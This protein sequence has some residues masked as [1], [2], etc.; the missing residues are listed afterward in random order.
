MRF[1]GLLLVVSACDDHLFVSHGNSGTDT[2]ENAT[3]WCAVQ[4]IIN[5]NCLT[6]QAAT[7]NPI[8]GLDLETDP[9]AALVNV[10]SLYD[11]SMRV[12]PNDPDGSL[13]VRKLEGDA[14]GI[15][16]PTGALPDDRIQ[17]VRDWIADGAS[18]VCE[19]PTTGGT[20]PN[21]YHPEGWAEPDVHGM[22]TKFQTETD[23]RTCHGDDLQGGSVGIS[24]TSCHG[25]GW[26]TTC[27]FCHGDP[28]D[29]TGAPPQDIDD[30]TNMA[31]LSFPPHRLH[32]DSELHA[33]WDC[34]QCHTKPTSA[35]F[36][37]HLFV[38]DTPGQAE[39][40]FAA[41][42]SDLGTYDGNGSC[43]NLY[44]HGN[45]RGDNGSVDLTDNVT[46]ESCHT[47]G[48]LGGQ[49]DEHLDEGAQCADCHDTVNTQVDIVLPAQHVNGV[50]NLDLPPGITTVGQNCTGSCHLGDE[51]EDHEGYNWITGEDD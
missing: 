10:P 42:L 51:T 45:G 33:T 16:P 30:N 35:L 44:C 5:G 12:A 14:G 2:T 37:G 6:C 11:G 17:L 50:V 22:A 21:R 38:D 7:P 27:T 24:C 28:V 31:T 46:C 18:D 9:Y 19:D 15:M 26:E 3:G 13:L 4:S 48:G 32:I 39:V 36:P 25:E 34:T 41:G 8:G 23:C 29:G 47:T 49:H 40:T 20:V 1:L 43:S